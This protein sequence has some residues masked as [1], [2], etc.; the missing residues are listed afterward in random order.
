M[1]YI[2]NYIKKNTTAIMYA[3]NCIV[4]FFSNDVDLSN[5]RTHNTMDAHLLAKALNSLRECELYSLDEKLE[6]AEE[7]ITKARC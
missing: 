3:V 7:D 1:H 5:I 4:K 6:R 2:V